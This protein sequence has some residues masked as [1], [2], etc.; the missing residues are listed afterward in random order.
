M[1]FPCRGGEHPQI[2]MESRG[3]SMCLLSP[4]RPGTEDVA[5]TLDGRGFGTATR[6]ACRAFAGR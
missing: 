6:G 1:D 2:R 3:K 4:T 5:W